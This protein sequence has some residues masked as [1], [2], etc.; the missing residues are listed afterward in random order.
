MKKVTSMHAANALSVGSKDESTVPASTLT[1]GSEENRHSNSCGRIQDAQILL[2]MESH[3][4]HA[5][6]CCP[7]SPRSRSE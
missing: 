1:V 3:N 7:T 4:E 6:M 5:L 2:L